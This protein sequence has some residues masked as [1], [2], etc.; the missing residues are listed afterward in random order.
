MV[1]KLTSFGLREKAG[2]E[3]YNRFEYQVHWIVYHMINEYKKDSQFYVFCEFHDDMAKTD[4]SSKPSCAEFYQIKTTS[5]FKEWTFPRLFKTYKK[6][7]E[8]IKHSFLGFIFYNYLNFETECSSCHF[9]SNIGMDDKVRKWQACIEDEKKL[10]KEEP[11]LYKEIRNYMVVE[12]EE[13]NDF[14]EIFEKFVQNTFLYDG[15]LKL[16]NYE[17]VVSGAF[18]EMLS[19]TDIFTSNSNKILKDII[20]EVRRKSKQTIDIPISYKSLQDKKGI[21]SQVFSKIKDQIKDHSSI[22][23]TYIVIEDFLEENDFKQIKKNILI[24]RLKE[25]HRKIMDVSNLLYQDSIES[26]GRSINT[27]ITKY[28][29]EID[30]IDFLLSYVKDEVIKSNDNLINDN[31]GIDS[32][33]I[34]VL[35]YESLVN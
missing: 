8:K 32:I 5:Q 12:F 3:S 22:D 1:E 13:E 17:R 28:Y 23:Q 14:D 6:K 15:D 18:F 10:K 7:N 11:E 33:L 9:V 34:E 16:D 35:F 20:E 31:V 4:D 30:N 27:V 25:H 24:K 19:E 29:D 21:S 2:S 26:I